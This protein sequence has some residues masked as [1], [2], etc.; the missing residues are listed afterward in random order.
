[1]SGRGTFLLLPLPLLDEITNMLNTRSKLGVLIVC[2][3]SLASVILLSHYFLQTQEE[4]DRKNAAARMNNQ[5]DAIYTAFLE[6]FS[7]ESRAFAMP[8][9]AAVCVAEIKE[10]VGLVDPRPEILYRLKPTTSKIQ[11]YSYCKS[12]PREKAYLLYWLAGF[13]QISDTEA[14]A[15]IG[16]REQADGNYSD[17]VTFHLRKHGGKWQ[18]D[19]VGAAWIT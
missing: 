18:I 14:F 6:K 16:F 12:L 4:D 17:G 19:E 3:L 8:G 15:T 10:N 5:F 7:G 11:P 2:V 1:M 9:F 13:T